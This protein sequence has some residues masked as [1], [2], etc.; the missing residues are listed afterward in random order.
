VL[1]HGYSDQTRS[2]NIATLRR[3]GYPPKQASAIAYRIQRDEL[4]KRGKSTRRVA[5]R[6]PSR[7]GIGWGWL[8]GGALIGAAGFVGISKMNR[9]ATAPAMTGSEI[10]TNAIGGAGAGMIVTGIV[11][12]VARHSPATAGIGIVGGGAALFGGMLFTKTPTTA[13]TTS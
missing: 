1:R 11:G 13:S 3:E 2:Q 4:K 12:G 7:K 8:A 9:P 10:A 6:N 5:R